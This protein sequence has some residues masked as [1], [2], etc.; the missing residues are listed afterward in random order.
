MHRTSAPN[1]KSLPPDRAR[2]A[3]SDE[4]LS[5]REAERKHEVALPLAST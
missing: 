2:V 5:S 4:R 3:P 1:G